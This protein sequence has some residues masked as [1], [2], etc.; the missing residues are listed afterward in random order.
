MSFMP[1][2]GV[3]PAHAQDFARFEEIGADIV[4]PDRPAAAGHPVA[5]F[6]IDAVEFGDAATP[7]RGRASKKA[8]PAMLEGMIFLPDA[9]PAIEIG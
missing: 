9:R 2:Y 7:D 4:R 6:E 5:A 3:E 8:E 1:W